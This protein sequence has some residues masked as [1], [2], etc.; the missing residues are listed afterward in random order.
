M[1]NCSAKYCF[2]PIASTPGASCRGLLLSSN[3][4]ATSALLHGADITALTAYS[5]ELHS[6]CLVSWKQGVV[7]AQLLSDSQLHHCRDTR[8]LLASGNETDAQAFIAD[9]SHKRLWQLLAEHALEK[10]DLPTAEKAFVQCEDYQGVQLIKHLGQLGDRN[11]QM[12]E[13]RSVQPFSS[14]VRTNLGSF[15]EFVCFLH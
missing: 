9:N 4:H 13:V 7:L 8:A 12:A 6:W 5:M 15:V 14:R 3:V 2:E 10:L 11:K 1:S